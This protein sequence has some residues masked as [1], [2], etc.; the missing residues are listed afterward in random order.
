MSASS[1]KDLRSRVE[2]LKEQGE[3][4]RARREVQDFI[5]EHPGEAQA[6]G[7]DDLLA[8]LITLSPQP[9]ASEDDNWETRLRSV[10]VYA[11]AGDKDTALG[12][13]KN[14][15]QE[16]PDSRRV[17]DELTKLAS[18]YGDYREDV[19]R[20]LGSMPP[21]AAIDETLAAMEQSVP[22][23]APTASEPASAAGESDLE[24]AMRLYRTRH[25]HGAV[26]I[27]DRLIRDEPYYTFSGP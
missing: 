3:F 16:Q 7:L 24:Q 11:E 23:E 25:H 18:V 14:M 10:R 9:P 21:N 20:F 5:N 17:L 6:D 26:A 22:A 19:V 12:I 2:T 13:L 15:L 1:V 4:L 8:S 27:F